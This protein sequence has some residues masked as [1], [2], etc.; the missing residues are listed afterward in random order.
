MAPFGERGFGLAGVVVDVFADDEEEEE[1]AEVDAA[2]T[3]LDCGGATSNIP[4]AT[5][6]DPLVGILVIYLLR[7]H[8]RH[9]AR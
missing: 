3:A 9:D 6:L 4:L 5:S 8:I 7:I 2:G 1:D